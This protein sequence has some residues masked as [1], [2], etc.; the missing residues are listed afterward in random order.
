MMNQKHIAPTLAPD[1]LARQLRLQQDAQYAQQMREDGA[2]MPEGQ[3]V[4]GHYVAP[5]ITQYLAQGLKSYMGGRAAADLPERMAGLQRDQNDAVAGQFGFP[6]SPQALAQGLAPA[7]SYPVN[8]QGGSPQGV[9]TQQ[10]MTLPGLSVEQSRMALMNLGPAEYMKM[11]QKQFEPTDFQRNAAAAGFQPGSPEFQ[12]VM[13]GNIERSNYIAPVSAAPGSTILDPKTGMPTF[14]APQD[15]RQV[16]YDQQGNPTVHQVPGWLEADAAQARAQSAGQ[17]EGKV[18]GEHAGRTLTG[19]RRREAVRTAS[20]LDQGIA[21]LDR[22]KET[23]NMLLKHPGFE[24]VSGLS[25]DRAKSYWP[26]TEAADAVAQFDALKS[27]I[28]QNVLQMYR[29][30]SETGGAVGQVSNFEQ[31]LFQN[32]LAALSRMQSPESMRE[33]L[34]RIVKFVDESS[35]R[36]R[37]AYDREYG[38]G[39]FNQILGYE[40][41]PAASPGQQTDRARQLDEIL[42][43]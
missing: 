14:H 22:M 18:T 27:Q 40:N 41:S 2:Q 4:S 8:M 38:E 20:G 30:M 16:R 33:S 23:A 35:Q 24:G 19:E 15:G 31:Q 39:M 21:Q 36:M 5:S 34:N 32:N 29:Q 10:P 11:Y 7:Q 25:W 9:P 28:A 1:L 37:Q 6:A 12:N 17:A 42:G 13:A 26:S 43:L 3:M